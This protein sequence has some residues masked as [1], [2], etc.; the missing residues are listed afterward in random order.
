MTE[1]MKKRGKEQGGEP[2]FED[3]LTQLEKIVE[4]LEGGDLPLEESLRLYEQGM[5]LS[6]AC[7][8]RLEAAQRRIEILERARDGAL[9]ELPFAAESGEE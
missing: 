3:S 2:G 1:R 9:Q 8:D 4:R 7:G 6:R 5:K